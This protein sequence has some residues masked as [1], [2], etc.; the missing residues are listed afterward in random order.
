M[1]VLRDNVGPKFDFDKVYL[2]YQVTMHQQALNLVRETADSVN[3]PQF[4]QFLHN[5]VPDLQSHLAAA[6]SLSSSH[7]RST[8]LEGRER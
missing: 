2:A 5:A 3:D 6:Q 8:L 1:E 4:Q 7:N